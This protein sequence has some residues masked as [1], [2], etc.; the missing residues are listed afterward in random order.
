M[1]TTLGA[2][3]AAYLDASSAVTVAQ[4]QLQA[5]QQ[6]LANATEQFH[7]DLTSSGVKALLAPSVTPSGDTPVALVGEDGSITIIVA[8]SPNTPVGP[9]PVPTP[10]PAP[11]PAPALVPAPAPA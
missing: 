7:A 1:S 2:D 4:S 3:F 9:V 8:A 10:A 11:I 6:G 5:S